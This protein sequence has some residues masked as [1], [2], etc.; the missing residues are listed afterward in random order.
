MANDRE[1]KAQQQDGTGSAENIDKDRQ[2]QFNELTELSLEERMAV[3]NR[4]GVPV[5]NVSDAD[6]LGTVSGRDDAAGELDDRMEEEST[7][8]ET[9][10]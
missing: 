7:S 6:A 8:E 10:R 1:N 5:E 3:A 2:E 9:D 4:I